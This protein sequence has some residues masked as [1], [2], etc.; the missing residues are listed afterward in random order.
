[1]V[2]TKRLTTVYKTLGD[3]V[4]PMAI[5][6]TADEMSLVARTACPIPSL[7]LYDLARLEY[8][9]GCGGDF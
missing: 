9:N 2:R 1:A 3:S 7:Q 8:I 4:P 5:I 6:V